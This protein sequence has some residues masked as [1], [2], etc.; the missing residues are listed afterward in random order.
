MG[1][2]DWISEQAQKAGEWLGDKADQAGEWL[3]DKAAEV[4]ETGEKLFEDA[5]D[6]IVGM[7][8]DPGGTSLSLLWGRPLEIF[9][10]T[11]ITPWD[12]WF[13]EKAE[14]VGEGFGEGVEDLL[15]VYQAVHRQFQMLARYAPRPE[16]W[17]DHWL[18][19]QSE[20]YAGLRE[21]LQQVF[22]WLVTLSRILVE[23]P[24]Y[25]GRIVHGFFPCAIANYL[26]GDE[27]YAKVI[28]GIVN[29][30]PRFRDMFKIRRLPAAERYFISSDLHLYSEGN[31]DVPQMQDTK[32]LYP[33]VLE[34]Y[35][36]QNYHLIENGDVEDYWLE[37]GSLYG[38]AFGVSDAF[39]TPVDSALTTDLLI[40]A[41][42]YHL[43]QVHANNPDVYSTIRGLFHG[44]GRYYRTFGNH[45][46]VYRNSYMVT[47]LNYVYSSADIDVYEYIVLEDGGEAIG[48]ICHGHQTDSWNNEACSVLGKS[49]TTT[50]MSLLRD[51]SFGEFRRGIPSR[52]DTEDLWWGVPGSNELQEVPPLFGVNSGL[53]SL[54]EVDL[55][56]TFQEVWT[57]WGAHDFDS[58][59]EG[60]RLILGH[61]HN[62]HVS[63]YHPLH[64]AAWR[65]YW[66]SGCGVFYKAITGIEWDGTTDPRNP[67]IT[68]VGWR[69]RGG[70][71]ERGVFEPM[72]GQPWIWWSNPAERSNV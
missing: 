59:S 22:G 67:T 51:I 12:I 21:N 3:S 7:L 37:G 15:E 71:L 62:P 10:D 24:I 70:R 42:E 41:A 30:E 17:L 64:K 58:L 5:V 2:G 25:A 33:E 4:R 32:Q 8:E 11:A 6:D 46:D 61:T 20:D 53:G 27:Y 47:A 49:V 31:L 16:V 55:F 68:P 40:Q 39:P 13:A 38:H 23:V 36:N 34:Y 26:F 14:G 18:A 52:E 60:P 29:D 72:S 63:P 35:G 43:E 19:E 54:D 48:L 57:A 28:E 1:L 56:H 44:Q 69:S 50:F 9:G 66:N 65:R 45:D